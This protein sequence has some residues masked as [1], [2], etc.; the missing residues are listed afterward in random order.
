MPYSVLPFAED[1]VEPAARLFLD[2][3]RREQSS[4]P[5]LPSRLL[6]DPAPIRQAL[7]ARLGNPGVVIVQGQ[8][9]LA[10]MLEGARFA[11]KGQQA[12]LVPEYGHAAVEEDKRD[13]Y[14]RLYMALAQEWADQHVHLHLLGHLA[15]DA[16]LQE[17]I[18]QLGL[19]AILAERLRDL[20]AVAGAPEVRIVE[21]RDPRRLLDLQLEH[22]RY[23]PQSPIFVRKP[24]DQAEVLAELDAQVRQGDLFLVAHDGDEP[25]AYV[26]VGESTHEGEGFLLQRTNTAQIKSAYAR[27]ASRG[28]GIAT[29]LLRAAVAWAQREGFERLF[30]EHETANYSGGRFWR[31]HFWPYV[32]FS[33]RYIDSS[34]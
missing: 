6:E 17:T 2:A 29:A 5:L 3:Y 30:V 8:R 28:K 23:Y 15:H 24:V 18:Y 21:E 20:S 1:H 13:L 10:Y 32:C 26:T 4:S 31:K 11:W 7:A 12:A 25:G 34:M 33:M 27:P 19:G 14:Q 9:V 22:N 16:V